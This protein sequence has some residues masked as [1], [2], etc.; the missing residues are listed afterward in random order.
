MFKKKL[1]A[2]KSFT[3][4]R[5]GDRKRLIQEVI[6]NF[7][8]PLSDVSEEVSAEIKAQLVP[9]KIQTA[10]FLTHT[11]AGGVLYVNDG[12]EKP[13]WF[14]PDGDKEGSALVPSL[15]TLWRNPEMLPVVYTPKPVLGPLQNGA[16]LMVRGMVGPFPDVKTGGLTAVALYPSG[17]IVAVGIAAT[18]FRDIGVSEETSKGKGVIILHAY[19]DYLW[20]MGG[21]EKLPVVKEQQKDEYIEKVSE[22]SIIHGVEN[23][24]VG[25]DAKEIQIINP[26]S[27]LSQNEPAE[28]IDKI[29]KNDDVAEQSEKIEPSLADIDNAYTQ[30]ALYGFHKIV[31][32]G[33]E[34]EIELPLS[35]SNYMSWHVNPYLL[36]PFSGLG[37]KK[38]SWKKV[39]A[40]IKKALEK[41]L[42][43]VRTRERA[44]D[45]VITGVDWKSKVIEE[46][47]PYKI[48]KTVVQKPQGAEEIGQHSQQRQETHSLKIIE[49]YRPPSKLN[50]L[51]DAVAH[52]R[53]AYYSLQ[54]LRY[55][56]LTYIEKSGL[57]SP[58]NPKLVT[59]EDALT[60]LLNKTDAVSIK[61]LSREDLLKKLVAACQPFHSIQ[62]DDEDPIVRKGLT[63]KVHVL[64]ETRMGRKTVTRVF[65][66]ED[67]LID[68]KALGEELRQLCASSTAVNTALENKNKQEVLVQGPQTSAVGQALQCHGV[69]KQW[70][71]VLDKRKK[72]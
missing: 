14:R 23:M 9:A 3:S 32:E 53:K 17:P 31:K 35:S 42:K 45:I 36:A 4:I 54:E 27:S 47:E 55:V 29:E 60:T 33:R 66:V 69:K 52:D 61:E 43:L 58:K 22:D 63:P 25:T 30:A 1:Q 5:S 65:D 19:G 46:F 72:K 70:I 24:E 71:E 64:V 26:P 8:V 57:V 34:N 21:K 51:F 41:D 50:T 15:S 48:K 2:L 68:P 11:D 38:S 39:S 6:D 10:R 37:I 40:F 62:R 67:F 7:N 20:E 56:L 44:G 18:D 12:D 49:I 13:L 28:Q 59:V 16:D